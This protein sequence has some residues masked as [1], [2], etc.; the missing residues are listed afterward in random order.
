MTGVATGIR[1]H[2]RRMRSIPRRP[3]VWYRHRPF[4]PTDVVI[5]EYPKSGETWLNFM[6]AEIIFGE[7]VGFES[8]KTFIP[9]VGLGRVPARLPDSDVRIWKTHEQHRRE[10]RKAVYLV[11][12]VGDVAVSYFNFLAWKKLQ[13]ME[14]KEFLEAFLHSRV[15]PYG[16]W[17]AHVTSWLDATDADVHVVRYEDLRRDTPA[18]LRS[19]LDFL[20]VDTQQGT[21][22]A[23][24]NGNTIEAMRQKE[25]TARADLFKR[26]DNDRGGF[27]RK[28]T[29]GESARWLDADDLALIEEGAGDALRRLGYQ[30]RPAG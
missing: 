2:A 6:L 27:V 3:V 11:R 24:I 19:I 10:Y 20:G 13:T 25:R 16:S 4:E 8:V 28:G 17:Q 12:H 14:F 15:S 5:A 1:W 29:A 26:R 30:V 22:E 23:A 18:T 9:G 7:P 21:L